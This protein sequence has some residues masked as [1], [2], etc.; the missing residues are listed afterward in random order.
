MIWSRVTAIWA[1]GHHLSLNLGEAQP[2]H[3]DTRPPMCKITID[4]TVTKYHTAVFVLTN[5]LDLPKFMSVISALNIP[6]INGI[7]ISTIESL[8]L[9]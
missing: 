2:H 1:D 7:K 4:S 6:E 9:I 5:K 8:I 3:W